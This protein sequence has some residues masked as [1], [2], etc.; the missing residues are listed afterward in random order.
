MHIALRSLAACVCVAALVPGCETDDEGDSLEANQ[1]AL[2][3]HVPLIPPE[4][5][6]PEGS[7]FAFLRF[8][9]GVQIYDCKDGAWV[10][11]APEAELYTLLGWPAGTHYAG[12][13]W[14]STD[15]STVKG[16][17]VAGVTVDAASIPWLLLQANGHGGEGRM[18]DVSYVQRLFTHGGNAP[19][20]ACE[21]GATVDVA[22]TALYTFYR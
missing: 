17:R 9:E 22:Y 21:L 19:S 7:R 1:Q 15:G 16:A 5:A 20:G 8:A 14:E 11:R 10:F 18:A 3:E 2:R 4:L 6:V 13:T 12:P